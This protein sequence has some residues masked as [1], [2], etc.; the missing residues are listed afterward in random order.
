MRVPLRLCLTVLTVWPLLAAAPAWAALAAPALEGFGNVHR[1]V[2]GAAPQV[3]A[4]FDQ[5]LRQAYAFDEAEAARAFKAAL[6]LDP[7]CAMCAWGV[8]WQLGPNYNHRRRGDYAEARRHAVLAQQLLGEGATRL[9]RDLVAALVARYGEAGQ[10]SAAQIA[11]AEAICGAGKS[12][13]DP[14][15]VI[16]A[17][18]MR[19]LAD[20][21]PNDPDVQALFAEA[22]LI[23]APRTGYD[24]VTLVTSGRMRALF[25]RL[26]A[27]LRKHPQHTGLIHYYTH[28][29][30][31]PAE[32][33][34]AAPAA[35][36]L[37]RLA[38]DASHLVHMPSHL[39]M[40][41]GRYADAVRANQQ[42]LDAQRRLSATLEKQG[43]TLLTDW[44]AHNRRFLWIAA[45]IQGDRATAM[46]QARQLADSAGNR[47]D[48]WSQFLRAM[49]LLTMVHF[50]QW[51][52]ILYT[53]KADTLAPHLLA[54][55]RALARIRK[56]LAVEAEVQQLELHLA[57][58]AAQGADAK[59]GAAFAT[60]LLA[61]VKADQALARS[62]TASARA[63]LR[64]ALAA[65]ADFPAQEPPLWADS[66]QRNLGNVLL[67]ARDF[68][69]AESA[70]RADLKQL[71]NNVWALKGLH[72]A[73]QGQ[74]KKSQAAQVRKA[75]RTSATNADPALRP[76]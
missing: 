8:A 65:E 11:Q 67:R 13:G 44:N 38:P 17:Q 76:S 2:A 57:Q 3:Q 55:A 59:A 22:E 20:A 12:D 26:E 39:A 58:A 14:L 29:A 73:L 24:P 28:A 51:D 33:A 75:W 47:G 49:P 63:E 18:N 34:R 5:G 48:D 74:G 35:A 43:F 9:E 16:Y 21:N 23:A 54:Y 32:A 68:S 66:A 46:A 19:M 4:W 62:D 40:R 15:D 27:A 45:Q 50:G 71:P 10:A 1:P 36:L 6:Q 31:T 69:A 42:A 64:K 37:A 52:D 7:A 72:Q 25:D 30:D 70:F 56:G 60:M 41:L 61:Q 53:G